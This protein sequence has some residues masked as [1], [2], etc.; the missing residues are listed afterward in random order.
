MQFDNSNN[1]QNKPMISLKN[2][3]R[4]KWGNSYIVFNNMPLSIVENVSN[5]HSLFAGKFDVDKNINSYLKLFKRIN[6]PGKSPDYYIITIVTN[7]KT[8]IDSYNDFI[9]KNKNSS[10]RVFSSAYHQTENGCQSE[11]ILIVQHGDIIII[12]D[13]KFMFDEK[14]EELIQL[15]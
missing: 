6:V 14:L 2:S 10:S 12:N 4:K 7:T 8:K 3:D 1:I 11:T 5:N 15:T 9:K 13:E